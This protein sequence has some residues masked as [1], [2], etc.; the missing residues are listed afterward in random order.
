MHG[1]MSL[2]VVHPDFLSYH[3][4]AC[5]GLKLSGALTREHT[6]VHLGWAAR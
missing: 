1:G 3:A 2:L 5:H 4:T 6:I